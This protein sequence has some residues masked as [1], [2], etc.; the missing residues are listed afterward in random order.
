M[1]SYFI[2]ILLFIEF[3]SVAQSPVALVSRYFVP[4]HFEGDDGNG[5]ENSGVCKNGLRS[6]TEIDV[7]GLHASRDV[8]SLDLC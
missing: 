6:Q 4:C 1:H 8:S 3:R 5:E 7:K 2:I